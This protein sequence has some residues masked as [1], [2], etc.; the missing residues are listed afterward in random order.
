[1]VCGRKSTYLAVDGTR[2]QKI[3]LYR[4]KIKATDRAGMAGVAK[5]QRFR[6]AGQDNQL[7]NNCRGDI[8]TRRWK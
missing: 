6:D 2:G 4:V 7:M 5:D 3:C 1:V 8:R